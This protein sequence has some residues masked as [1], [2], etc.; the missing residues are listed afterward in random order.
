M[1]PTLKRE[2]NDVFAAMG[3]FVSDYIR[4]ALVRVAHDRVGPLRRRCPTH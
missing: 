2:A 1:S 4:M 3:L